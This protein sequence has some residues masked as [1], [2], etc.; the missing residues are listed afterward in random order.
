MRRHRY[1]REQAEM[2]RRAMMFKSACASMGTAAFCS[3]VWDLRYIKAAAAASL[4]SAPAPKTRGGG[5]TPS[6]AVQDYKALVCL[7]LFGG[8]D[9]NN[10]LVATDPTSFSTYTTAR[11]GTWAPT[12]NAS[13]AL[14]PV[15]TTAAD[16]NNVQQNIGV[17]AVTSLSNDGHTYGLHSACSEMQSLFNNG[18]LCFLANVGTMAYPITK[19]TLNS[20]PKPSQLFSHNDQQIQWQTS[21][22]DQPS[23]TGWG[24]RCS[25]VM[26]SLNSG[27]ATVSM[28][29]SLA[30]TNTW[31][32]GST[33]NELKVSTTGGLT[34][35]GSTGGSATEFSVLRSLVGDTTNAAVLKALHPNLQEQ[36]FAQT[37]DNGINSGAAVN[38]AITGY[39]ASIDTAFSGNTTSL[40]NQLKMISK[41]IWAHS[42]MGHNRQIYF[43][44]IGG[45]D[46]HSAQGA[47][48]AP[49]ASNNLV[50]GPHYNLLRDVSKSLNCFNNA[51]AGLGSD[52][53]GTPMSHRVTTF[54]VSDF[55]R[56]FKMNTGFGSDHG[57]G[58][59]QFIMGGAVTDALAA[60]TSG[61]VAGTT[62]GS[63][64]YGTFPDYTVGGQSDYDSGSG[65]TGRWIPGTSCDEYFSTLAQWFGV[66]AGN[67]SAILPNI[68]RFAH[69]NLGFV[70]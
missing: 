13:V 5:S 11:G 15:G 25:D 45:F 7:F 38:S 36:D 18:Q 19:A 62:V 37:F 35:N 55:S 63:K 17:L 3:T 59:H 24:G 39:P 12:N 9:A 14:A 29:I 16:K 42:K 58:N 33:I 44:S 23:R 31:E 50:F 28:S 34:C 27:T 43:A 10:L 40:A 70:V 46:L 30:G 41:L 20:T 57:W 21:V 54:S 49:D 4:R 60:N 48:L 65:A 64:V 69:P 56:T 47:A 2:T 51:I 53:T 22:A 26:N 52:A 8:N 68:G 67:L 1:N 32:V 61:Y 66:S 6:A